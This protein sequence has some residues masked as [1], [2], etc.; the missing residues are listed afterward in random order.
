[1]WAVGHRED[2]LAELLRKKFKITEKAYVF[3]VLLLDSVLFSNQFILSFTKIAVQFVMVRCHIPV[4]DM[5]YKTLLK[6]LKQL[7]LIIPMITL[8]VL[9]LKMF[10]KN[11]KKRI[12]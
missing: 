11:R 7:H 2:N 8:L 1:M 9:E 12:Y 10:C 3:L 6:N 5:H 4:V